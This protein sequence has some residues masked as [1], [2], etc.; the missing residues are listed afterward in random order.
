MA[1]LK[2]CAGGK[3]SS[4]K[5]ASISGFFS[6]G[7]VSDNSQKSEEVQGTVELDSEV[8]LT[9][10]QGTE[11]VTPSE[12]STAAG[13]SSGLVLEAANVLVGPHQPRSKD[14]FGGSF[15]RRQI[16]RQ[17]RSFQE[18]WYSQFPWL[19]YSEKVDSAFCFACRLA[20]Q[21][22]KHG[23]YDACFTE[24][25][26]RNWKTA[27][28]DYRKHESS[29]VHCLAAAVW[30]QARHVAES[31]TSVAQSVST[32]HQLRITLN[33]RNL[34]K[35]F[36]TI[37]YLGRQSIALRGHDETEDCTN[38][39]NFLELLHLRASDNPELEQHL[40]GTFTYTSP[41][42][43]NEILALCG[44]K[45]QQSIVYELRTSGMYGLICDETTDVSRQEQMS[46]CV[47]YVS[48]SMTVKERFL[49]FWPAE[50]TD[51]KS[52]F[53]L[54][55]QALNELG[56]PVGQMRAQ[57]YDGASNMRG[58]YKGVCTR[59]QEVEK[60][61]LYIH[62]H[63]HV[64]NLTLANA[65]SA[66][67]DIRNVLGVVN[68]L[69]KLLEGSAKRHSRFQAI[70]EKL[71]GSSV[72][73]KRLCETRWSSRYEAVHAI[74]SSFDAIINTLEAISTEDAELGPEASCL[75]KSVQ[76]FHFFFYIS[77]LEE[78]LGKTAVLSRYLQG[79]RVEL[80]GVKSKVSSTIKAVGALRE[81][82]QDV[83]KNT[84]DIASKLSLELPQLPRKRKVAQRLAMDGGGTPYYPQSCQEQ[85]KL[86]YN[87]V[88]DI[89]RM[90]MKERFRENEYEVLAAVEK[91]LVDSLTESRPD[92]S[93]LQTVCT[94]YG[95]DFN[96]GRLEHEL[97]IF[98]GNIQAYQGEP[99]WTVESEEGT[100][101]PELVKVRTF[102]NKGTNRDCYPET[103]KLLKTLLVIPASS[104]ECERSF[105]TLRR[106]KTWLRT[107]M[108]Q[109]R[110]T[111]LALLTVE[112]EECRK[113][114]CRVEDLVAEFGSSGRRRLLL[115]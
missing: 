111:S 65:C 78:V 110:L 74:K 61:A 43:Q 114:E 76:T 54:L 81:D 89:V 50:S 109:E 87:E 5:Q 36:E 72:T 80:S 41:Q 31:G 9:D 79:R 86:V 46:I 17:R 37:L 102:F 77:V 57:C 25:G 11:Q 10:G 108:G 106:L 4:K 28:D 3:G 14:L 97:E 58:R 48:E 67:Q 113:L 112:R 26:F 38:R 29:H 44:H 7:Q 1:T 22:G 69:Y 66:V 64:L 53:N 49:G 107:S 55:N 18:T 35:V 91:L 34:G 23:H 16:L 90:E 93:S 59:F 15:P 6:R 52:L 103:C 88:V 63:A 39:G 2:S 95:N 24:R 92:R 12:V 20:E 21:S 101:L 71:G 8:S 45:I 84:E 94:F 60:R 30:N 51:G 42:I 75:L 13:P 40:Q 115:N 32:A 70:Q 82:F 47:R 85:Y 99:D 98:Y 105:S 68:S 104:S 19:E 83:W 62:C 100:D 27:L 33:R 56:I 73:L 96:S